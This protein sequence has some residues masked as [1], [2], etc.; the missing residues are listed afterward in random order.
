MSWLFEVVLLFATLRFAISWYNWLS[1]AVLPASWMEGAPIK[2]SILIPARNEERQIE[3]VIKSALAQQ[4][5]L[6]EL[7]VLDDHSTDAT[8]K[9]A[10]GAMQG[11]VRARLL[12]GKDLP[13]GWLGKSWA[14]HQLAQEASGEWL[15]FIDADVQLAPDA[16]TRAL[17]Y[18]KKM[19]LDALSVFPF[20][21]MRSFGERLTVP[22][23]HQLL[24]SLLPLNFIRWFKHPS[25]AAAN[26]QFLLLSAAVYRSQQ[27]HEQ[28]RNDIV[29]DIAIFRQ[30]KA[31]GK[32]V[33]TLTDP[34]G[35]IRCRM[36]HDLGEG[37]R[38]FSKNVLAGFGYSI[39]GLIVYLCLTA[40]LWPVFWFW[41]PLREVIALTMVILL[42]R[43]MILRTAGQPVILNLLLHIPQLMVFHWIAW[44]SIYLKL[45]NT[46]EWKGRVLR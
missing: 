22:L 3:Q 27:P 36:Y 12:E 23:M 11:D 5:V 35:V 26:G 19:K 46:Y 43:V 37:V 39:P 40:Y 32:R 9:L 21:E 30:L 31:A 45:T 24:L 25:L 44:R 14:C 15:L 18:A 42:S 8:A 4:N 41:V 28:V 33:M 13:E 29:E 17:S 6:L 10:K 16:S 7:L 38:G 1:K 20:Q 2:L 34:E